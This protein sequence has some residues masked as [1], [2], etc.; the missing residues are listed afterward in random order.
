MHV[1]KR[2]TFNWCYRILGWNHL[3]NFE[4]TASLSYNLPFLIIPLYIAHFSASLELFSWNFTIKC[5]G[6]GIYVLISFGHLA[7]CL[8][9]TYF[10]QF[11]EILVFFNNYHIFLHYFFS[12]IPPLICFSYLSLLLSIFLPFVFNFV[13]EFPWFDLWLGEHIS[14]VTFL[15]FKSSFLF[16][17]LPLYSL[18]VL[19]HKFSIFPEVLIIR[20]FSWS[21][22]FAITKYHRSSGLN[23]NLFLTVPE[24]QKSKI[25]R[26]QGRFH[27]D[28]SWL[29]G[30]H[31]LAV[32]L[33]DPL[34]VCVHRERVVFLVSLIRTLTYRE[35]PPSW[36]HP[37]LNSSH[38]PHLQIPVG[39]G[40][41]LGLQHNKCWGNTNIQAI[42]CLFFKVFVFNLWTC[43]FF[44]G[45]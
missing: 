11:W 2:L 12:G 19:F 21:V 5:L 13:G 14:S 7:G 28:A 33:Q 15:I 30:C 41:G 38:R 29:V 34:Y 16:S 42:I 23:R 24:A 44:L 6:K 39:G 40:E 4:V 26:W 25:R 35:A 10:L 31:H 36:P 3:E 20:I 45:F 9:Q 43:I 27:S 37:T 22:Q 18:L 32:C 8:G 17:D 1:W